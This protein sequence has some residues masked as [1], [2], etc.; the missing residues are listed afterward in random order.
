[1]PTLDEIRRLERPSRTLFTVYLVRAIGIAI[2]ILFA[3]G[4][5]AARMAGEHIKDVFTALEKANVPIAAAIAGLFLVS[6]LLAS[7]GLYV[8][9]RTLRY[10]WDEDGLTR[11]WGL[12]FRRES[13][14]AYKRIQDA[15]VS[16]GVV[17]RFFGLGTVSIETASG[18]KGL[19]ESIEGM[20]EFQLVRDFLYERMRGHGAPAPAASSEPAVPA[21]LPEEVALVNA[22]RD[23]MRALRGAVEAR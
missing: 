12:L 15:K 8:R 16:Q 2:G 3:I 21:S 14:L 7:L 9:F 22:I 13:F 10:R 5:I 6:Y 1:M 18:S 19:E 23:E 17:E 11:Q 4:V 20:R